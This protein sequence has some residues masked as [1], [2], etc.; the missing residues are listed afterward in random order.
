MKRKI[1][2]FAL[3]FILGLSFGTFAADLEIVSLNSYT[4]S[5]GYL[6]VVGEIKNNSEQNVNYVQPVVSFKNSS[7]DTI[8]SSSTYTFL[9]VLKPGQTAPFKVSIKNSEDIAEY[10]VQVQGSYGG[11]KRNLEITN[12]NSNV[13][14]IGYLNV[15]GEIKN[16]SNSD[17]QY[18]EVIASFYNKN[19]EIVDAAYTYAQMDIVN[20][21]STSPFKISIQNKDSIEKYKLQVQ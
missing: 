20:A 13:D 17:L 6:N 16:N 1:T 19:G 2:I 4:D 18:V 8:D 12:S 14:S 3:V 7:G 10:A 9:D 11:S 21:G 15:N 5:I